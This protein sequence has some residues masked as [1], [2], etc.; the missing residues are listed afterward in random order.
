MEGVDRALLAPGDSLM[1]P[2]RVP[3]PDPE[4][5]RDLGSPRQGVLKPVGGKSLALQGVA[6]ST[7]KVKGYKKNA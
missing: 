5:E 1:D 6:S 2:E 3:P 4:R 7:S